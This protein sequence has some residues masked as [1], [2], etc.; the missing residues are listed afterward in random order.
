MA[1]K[2]LLSPPQHLSA[3]HG[4]HMGRQTKALCLKCQ[5]DPLPHTYIWMHQGYTC[6]R[7]NLHQLACTAQ[8]GPC[9]SNRARLK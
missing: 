9:V 3:M 1:V 4:Q 2:P 8:A 7:A 5:Q 6:C